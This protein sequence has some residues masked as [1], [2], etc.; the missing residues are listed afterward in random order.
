MYTCPLFAGVVQSSRNTLE[1][2][3][4]QILHVWA[5]SKHV[6]NVLTAAYDLVPAEVRSNT[7]V[8]VTTARDAPEI[9]TN[10]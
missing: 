3:S 7:V 10:K 9:F 6:A 1:K 8:L 2:W 5:P 4:K